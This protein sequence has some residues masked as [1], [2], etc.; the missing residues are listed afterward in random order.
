[1]NFNTLDKCLENLNATFISNLEQSLKECFLGNDITVRRKNNKTGGNLYSSKN[2]GKNVRGPGKAPQLSTTQNFRSKF[3]KS[4]HWLIYEELAEYCTQ[5]QLLKTCFTKIPKSGAGSKSLSS[6]ASTNIDGETVR[7]QFWS[8][9]QTLLKRHFSEC[10]GHLAQT[11]QEGLAKL[12]SSIRGFEQRM[13]SEFLFENNLFAHLEKGYVSK[14]SA[15]LKSTLTGIDV[16]NNDTIDNFIRTATAEMSAA[17]VDKNLAESLTKVL[18][19]CVKEMCAKLE[20]QIYLGIESA[21]VVDVPNSQQLQNT[22]MLNVLYYLKDSFKHMLNNLGEQFIQV[23][24]QSTA[25]AELL[26]SL[27]NVDLLINGILQPIMESIVATMKIIILTVH[28]EPG[29]NTDNISVA[30]PSMY[31]KELQ[32]FVNRVWNNHIAP[33]H[34]KE[35][36]SKSNREVAK[37]CIDFFI[38]NLCIIRP[39]SVAGRERLKNDCLYLEQVLKPLCASNIIELGKPARLLRAVAFLL[40]EL[41]NELIKHNIDTDNLVPPYLILLLLFGHAGSELQSPHTTVNW[42][43]ERFIEWLESHT[44]DREK[45]ELISGALQRYRDGVRR[46]KSEQYDIVYPLMMEFFET[47]STESST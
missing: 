3:W 36:V 42:S 1:M 2:S 17:L 31:M 7:K 6:K 41:P 9:V 37:R 16:P 44:N 20:S 27:E 47:V 28:R 22:H 5:I 21:Q 12:L 32:D 10:Q 14:C 18:I 13:K 39:L 43:N 45:L 25:Q 29:L 23:K 46:K 15:N 8:T 26:K 19:N 11:L 24:A 33:F 30:G 34:D 40:V 35:I 38:H 4:M